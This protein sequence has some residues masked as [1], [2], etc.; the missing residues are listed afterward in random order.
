MIKIL[1]E[2]ESILVCVKP[3]G[4]LSE[5]SDSPLSLPRTIKQ[6]YA[7]NGKSIELFTL[8][9]L[10]REVCGLIVF[11]KTKE[12]AAK[13]SALIA[14]GNMEK[15]YLAIVHGEPQP[16]QARLCDLL[17]KDSKKNKT[18]V[19]D[20]KRAGVR[21][22]MLDYC[23]ILSSNGTSLLKIKLYTGRSHQ[24]RAQLSHMGHP[25]LADRK[26]GSKMRGDG[27][28]L[29]SHFISFEHPDTKRNMSFSFFPSES[30]LWDQYSESFKQ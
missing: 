23:T 25:I 19:V 18:Y 8:H 2:D 13:M 26:Y 24:I 12:C 21:E 20:R 1:Y 5:D 15:L 16:P 3:T 9:R 6:E 28:A 4:T 30:S 17:F 22:A 27:I 10:D 11:A 29:C 14:N 7:L